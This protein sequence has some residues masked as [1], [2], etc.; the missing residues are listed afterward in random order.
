MAKQKLKTANTQAKKQLLHPRGRKSKQLT[1]ASLREDRVATKK[2]HHALQKSYE[3]QMYQFLQQAVTATVEALAQN[4]SLD[5]DGKLVEPPLMSLDEIHDLLQTWISRSDEEI[6]NLT[7]ERR[8]GRP[9]PKK[10]EQLEDVRK[11]ENHMYETGMKVPDMRDRNTMM[12]LNEWKGD[13]GG[14]TAMKHILLKKGDNDDDYI[15][16]VKMN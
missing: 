9:K 15:E 2:F 11:K 3:L 4:G 7:A 6:E 8:P 16:D 10:L 5:E 13:H 12:L 1:R 14:L